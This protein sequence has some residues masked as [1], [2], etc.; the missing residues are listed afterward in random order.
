M[1]L[2]CPLRGCSHLS[3]A[4]LLNS[5]QCQV[6]GCKHRSFCCLTACKAQ[7]QVPPTQRS[8]GSPSQQIAKR[9]MLPPTQGA[10]SSSCTYCQSLTPR[11]GPYHSLSAGRVVYRPGAQAPPRHTVSGPAQL[12]NLQ[13]NLDPQTTYSTSKCEKHGT[14]EPSFTM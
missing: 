13:F 3:Q 12:L 1:P 8:V 2:R 10:P 14:G 11:V 5:S 6:S 4:V 9:R 7:A